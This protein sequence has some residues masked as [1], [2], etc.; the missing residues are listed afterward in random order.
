M[1]DTQSKSGGEW[2]VLCVVIFC[3]AFAGYIGYE[4]GKYRTRIDAARH[5]AGEFYCPKPDKE[6][7]E[8]RW[9]TIANPK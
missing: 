4:L 2:F 5:G 3:M 9:T 7:A 8:W 6:H 1:A